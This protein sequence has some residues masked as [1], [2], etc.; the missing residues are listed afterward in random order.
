MQ[1]SIDSIPDTHIQCKK[2][3][4]SLRYKNKKS[5]TR[6]SDEFFATDGMTGNTRYYLPF[7]Q[8][9]QEKFGGKVY[10]VTIDAG[11][12]CPNRDGTLGHEGCIYCYGKRAANA[13]VDTAAIQTQ[14]REGKAA[15]TKRYHAHK[16]LAYFQSYTNTY[17]APE[18]LESLYTTALAEEGIV[19]LAIGTRPDCVPEPVLDVLET[20]AQQTYL[21][22]EYGLQSIHPHTLAFIK[23]GHTLETFLDAIARTKRRRGINIC[24][25]VILGLPGETKAD[26]IAT[27]QALS[28]LGIQGVKIHSAHILKATHL[29]AMYRAGEYHTL[30]LP[31]YVDLVCDFLEHL[32]PEIIIHRLV[33]D[34]PRSRYVAPE[35]CLH[36]AEA[37]RAIETELA[38]RNSYQGLH[39]K[40]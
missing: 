23:R 36:K 17:A 27:A 26:M 4:Y 6:N 10:K 40:K 22:V 1:K 7:S 18:M 25:H 35:W 19:G 31:E 14:I 24:V 37:L 5:V 30:E 12:T 3:D 11:F 39:V 9:L 15:I 20:L 29:E 13:L 38:R 21:W 32:A 34:A 33:G 2:L 8:H 28:Q 16:F